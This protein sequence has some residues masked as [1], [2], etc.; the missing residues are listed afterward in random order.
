MARQPRF[1][2]PGVPLHVIQRGNNR[3]NIFCKSEDYRFFLDI[4]LD[5]C[6]I[7]GVSVHAYVLMTN[8]VHLLATPAGVDALPRVLQSVGRRYV[9]HFNRRY[10]RTGT[11]WEGRYRAT[12][13]DSER[14][15]LTCMRY[16]EF[17]P[18][19]AGLADHPAQYSWS[20]CPANA[21]G[22]VDKLV[23]PHQL[24]ERL[25]RSGEDRQGAYRQLL[26][27]RP[28]DADIKAIREATNKNWALGD[29]RFTRLIEVISGRQ[30]APTRR[31]G[32][33]LPLRGQTP[34]APC[35]PE[36]SSFGV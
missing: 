27:V 15:F 32:T 2:V 30:S 12:V 19:R 10:G 31:C 18:V 28:D 36:S 1:F 22:V 7:H 17:N 33:V 26:Q 35:N 4:L 20:S 8:H 29:D 23:T 3:E 21:Q 11:L 16:I 24:Y 34:S 9:W 5:A 14:Y 6:R 25:G 13:I